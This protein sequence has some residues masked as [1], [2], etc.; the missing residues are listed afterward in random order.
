MI[1]PFEDFGI[2]VSFY[3]VYHD[4]ELIQDL[5]V[6]DT[7]AVLVMDYFGYSGKNNIKGYEGTIIRDLT[8]SIFSGAYN[9]ADYYFGSLRKWAGFWTGGYA[10]GVAP[11]EKIDEE[12]VLLRKSAMEAKAEYIAGLSKTK[13]YL[14][15]FS[16]AEEYLG[17]CSGTASADFR[18]VKLAQKLDIEA[19]RIQRKRNARIL[20]E[21]FKDIAL[22]PTIK[23]TDC[24]MFVPIHVPNG[25]RNKLMRYLIERDIYCPV[26]W[27][28]SKYH[29]LTNQTK[30]IYENEL[31]LVCDHRYMEDD[32]DR[33]IETIREFWKGE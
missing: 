14:M 5:S 22:F 28:I 19:I 7:D 2:E 15:T 12:Y 13:D 18:D 10:W 24:P 27:P 3:P 8:H 30:Q 29:K 1:V 32:M 23:D 16:A 11:K 25:K 26:H 21:Q 33:I 6:I 17:N 31:S 20:L 4:G 9:D